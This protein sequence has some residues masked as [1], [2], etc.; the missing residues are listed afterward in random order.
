MLELFGNPTQVEIWGEAARCEPIAWYVVFEGYCAQVDFPGG[1]VWWQQTIHAFPDAKVLHTE[2]PEEEWWAS[3]SKTVLKV[4]VN[5]ERLTRNMPHHL[6]DIFL[7]LPPFYIDATFG[8]LTDKEMALAA[9]RRNNRLVRE[10]VPA[11][12]LL[13]FA[14]SDG[15]EPLCDFLIVPVPATPFPRSNWRG[16]FWDNFEEESAD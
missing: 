16:E 3:F 9:Y 2:R 4:W 6:Q 13:V 11:D 12:H 14:P 1:R 8:G 7:K 10:L 15:W 5:H